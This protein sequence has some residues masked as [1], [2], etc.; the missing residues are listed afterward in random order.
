MGDVTIVE[1]FDYHCPYCK[2]VA[3]PLP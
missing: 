3:S 2:A 1:F